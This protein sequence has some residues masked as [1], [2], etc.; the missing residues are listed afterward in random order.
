MVTDDDEEVRKRNIVAAHDTATSIEALEEIAL[1]DGPPAAPLAEV[2]ID[3]TAII[4]VESA[5]RRTAMIEEEANIPPKSA[6]TAA[7]VIET[8]AMI[9]TGPPADDGAHRDLVLL[10]DGARGV[11]LHGPY[12]AK[13]PF[14][15]RTTHSHRRK[16][17]GP[18]SLLNDH[19]W[20]SKNQI[21]VIQ[22]AWLQ[23]ATQSMSMGA[24]W[25]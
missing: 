19:R 22:G 6:R 5:R 9:D 15:P 21:L 2:V 11:P 8:D 12:N 17:Q 4:A 16:L 25:F 20:K 3:G 7:A 18:E 14:L 1:E 13:G 23:R 10:P 24:R